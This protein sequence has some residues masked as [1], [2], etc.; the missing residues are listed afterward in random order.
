MTR[1]VFGKGRQKKFISEAKRATNLTWEELGQ[2]VGVSGRTLR[3]WK[4]ERLLGSG[5]ELL[6][7]SKNSGISLPEILE[8]KEEYW[9]ARKQA[10]NGAYAKM[11]IYGP[12]GTPEGRRKGGLVSQQRRRENPE[13]YE[14]CNLRK[15][16]FCPRHSSSLA[17]A[18]GI[19]LGDGGIT[20]DQ[21]FITLNAIADKNYVLF[22]ES[23]FADLFKI[24]VSKRR[25]V[26]ALILY[27]SGENLV[28]F[29]VREG[30]CVGNKVRQ[31]VGVPDWITANPLYSRSCL[32]GLM[33]TDG[34][35]F[36]HRYKVNG[37]KYSYRK[38]AFANRSIPILKFA[39]DTLKQFKFNPKEAFG[40]QVLLYSDKE[41]ERYFKVIGSHNK[42]LTKFAQ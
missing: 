11:R 40:I 25:R 13:R 24:K 7:L 17:E 21:V 29:L 31:Q 20:K 30:L 42:R 18:F 33:D 9:S 28:E 38:I 34:C 15:K 3:D 27:M 14:N 26:N 4:G 12:P 39:K 1:L 36:I 8:T 41:F 23:F 10:K 5:K 37:K 35:A 16:V 19:L 6:K 22:V 2:S 32:R